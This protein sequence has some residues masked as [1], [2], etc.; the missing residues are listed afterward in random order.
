[1]VPDLKSVTRRRA[2]GV[3]VVPLLMLLVSALLLSG[4]IVYVFVVSPKGAPPTA[5][6]PEAKAYVRSLGL[7]EVQMKAHE[8]MLNST[9]VEITGKITNKGERPLRLVE[10]NC[11]FY[12]AYGQPVHRERVPIVRAKAGALKPAEARSFRLAFDSLPAGWNQALP[13][14]VIANIDFEGQS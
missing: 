11:V 4:L 5:L 7:S 3:G 13:Q 12:D 8:S 2:R 9:L 10:I 14:L 1:V 6:T